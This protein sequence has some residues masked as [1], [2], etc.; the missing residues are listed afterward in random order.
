MGQQAVIWRLL[1]RF[2]DAKSEAL[3]ALDAFE[4]PG[5]RKM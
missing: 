5:L 2:G 1:W 3:R 4:K